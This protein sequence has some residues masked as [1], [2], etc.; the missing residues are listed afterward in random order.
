MEPHAIL[1]LF[2]GIFGATYAALMA[3]YKEA[4]SFWQEKEQSV[5][6]NINRLRHSNKT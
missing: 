2:I 3:I 6:D 1:S 4:Y 5:R